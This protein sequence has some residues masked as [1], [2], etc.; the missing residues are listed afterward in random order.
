M[1]VVADDD[2]D[3]DEE[4]V[5]VTAD[6][7]Y[8]R[9]SVR[10]T[11]KFIVPEGTTLP[12]QFKIIATWNDQTLE[13]TAANGDGYT[14]SGSGT[15]ESP[16]TW[17]IDGLPIGASIAFAE[18]D[19]GI[20]GYNWSGTVSV[21]GAEATNAVEGTVTVSTEIQTVDFEN[22]YV[23]GVELP[24][25]GGSGTLLYTVSGLMLILLAGVLLMS[26]KRKYNR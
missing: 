17:T 14:F 11:K 20:P 23:A 13:L 6:N 12:E 9:G 10:V 1:T 4:T 18:T 24:A 3:E 15:E 22:T 16:Y 21:N 2:T 19:Y 7:S 5:V 25:T 26:R 8:T